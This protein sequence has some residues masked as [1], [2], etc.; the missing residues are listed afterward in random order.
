M[1]FLTGYNKRIKITIDADTHLSGD[2][3]DQTVAVVLGSDRQDFW[4]DAQRPAFGNE[5]RFTSSNG[6]T[7]LDFQLQSYASAVKPYLGTEKGTWHVQIPTLSSSV[8]TVIYIY[9][10]ADTPTDGT[11]KEGTWDSS[12]KAVYHF[13]SAQNEG[14]LDDA[15][16]NNNNLTDD[17]TDDVA[18]QLG[19]ARDYVKANTDSMTA[20]DSASLSAYT[21]LTIEAWVNMDDASDGTIVSKDDS[22][23]LEWYFNTNP[24][25]TLSLWIFDI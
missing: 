3:T 8:D 24:T 6:T 11:D 16:S 1:A 20:S 23:Q 17:G 25:D 4:Q 2:L 5:V 14:E 9:Y 13:D 21:T 15:T 19:R 22:G 10:R 12:Y 18:G 7:L